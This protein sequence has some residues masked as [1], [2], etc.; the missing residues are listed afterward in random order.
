MSYKSYDQSNKMIPAPDGGGASPTPPGPVQ[1]VLLVCR[2]VSFD[3]L[4]AAVL[5]DPCLQPLSVSAEDFLVE[6]PVGATIEWSTDSGSNWF[7]T[8]VPVTKSAHACDDLGVLN[9]QFRANA[10]GPVDT[11]ATVND[12]LNVCACP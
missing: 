8:T 6:V 2:P 4:D 12:N 7:A 5:N 10:G 1:G 9:V 11:Y 3:V